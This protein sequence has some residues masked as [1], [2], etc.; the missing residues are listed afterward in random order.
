M[1]FV[2]L[3]VSIASW[4]SAT[5]SPLPGGR[6]SGLAG[7]LESISEHPLLLQLTTQ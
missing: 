4:F 7:F 5:A 6:Y 2:C 3:T 1:R